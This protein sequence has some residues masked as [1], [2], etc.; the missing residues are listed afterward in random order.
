MTGKRLTALLAKI[1]I[2]EQHG[3][4]DP[5]ITD[6]VYDSREVQQ[7]SLF[8][9]LKGLHSDGHDYIEKAL[10]QGAAAVVH[11]DPLPRY[12]RGVAYL[13]VE[14]SRRAMSPIACSFYD[15][16]SSEM[17]IIGVTGTDGKS[18]TS[19]FIQQLLQLSGKPAGLL[20]TVQFDLGRGAEKNY[21]RQSTPEATEIHRLLRAMRE[22][23]CTHAVVEATSHGLSPLNNRLGDV[24]FDVGVLTNISHEH[25]EFHKTLERYIDDKAN[26]FR[27]LPPET[28]IAVINAEEP[29]RQAFIDAAACP[30]YFYGISPGAQE[31]PGTAD[32]TASEIEE[33]PAGQ[34]FFISRKTSAAD[35]AE[36]PIQT[37]VKLPQPG[38]FNVENSLAAL[39]ALGH[40]PGES[41]QSYFPLIA[42]LKPIKGRMVPVDEGQPFQVIVDYAHTPGSFRKLFPALRA[43][44][45]T[46]KLIAVFSS[47]GERDIEKRSQLGEI[48]AAYCDII[49]LADEDPRGEVPLD[50]L[51][52]VAAGCG[53]MQ[54]EH[55]LF[56][57][58]DRPTAIRYAFTLANKGDLVV[59]LGK[60]HEG[61]I[62]YADG[63]IPW[64]EETVAREQLR[65][66]G[67]KP[68]NQ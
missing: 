3:P 64:D 27:A 16:P 31:P 36:E 2:I 41:L 30:V 56:L 45:D 49:V 47:A 26:L 32:L 53:S 14:N 25:L 28:G 48:A 68:L 51:E 18:T 13:R 10:A 40:L 20:T 34:S 43:Q 7:G 37:R 62:I 54:R 1:N 22:N 33:S 58:E 66:L 19:Y 4:S 50:I 5:P 29:H 11:S 38:R 57:I 52:D 12:A 61:S 59:L 44:V 55:E 8:F 46:G 42:E 39:L 21:L 65:R 67:Y 23:G 35:T 60:G 9:A 6:L 17:T 24:K 63:P 15:D